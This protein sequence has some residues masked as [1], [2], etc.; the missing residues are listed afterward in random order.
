MAIDIA[1][2]TDLDAVAADAGGALDRTHQRCLFDRLDWYRLLLEHCPPAGEPLIVRARDGLGAVWLLL[3]RRSR[4]AT[5]LA[6][7]YSLETGPVTMGDTRSELLEALAHHLRVNHRLTMI[8]LAPMRE[9]RLSMMRAAFHRAGWITK[10]SG[11]STN[12]SICIAGPSWPDYLARR[13]GRLQ[14]TLRRKTRSNNLEIHI[15][16]QFNEDIWHSYEQIYAS[17]WKPQE[18]SPAFL[19]A[20]AKQESAAGTL[21]LGL[22]FDNGVPIAAQ[23]WLVENGEATIH[24]LAHAHDRRDQSPGTILTAAMFRHAIE[25]DKVQRIDFGTGNDPYKADWMDLSRP[26]FQLDLF[27]PRTIAGLTGALRGTLSTARTAI[28]RAGNRLRG[29]RNDRQTSD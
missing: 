7:W 1:S 23:F 29:L 27:N 11:I 8:S 10:C 15:I 19:T 3:T 17:S 2:F 25:Q 24:K 9:D 22:A 20:L 26:L 21:R 13:P 4:H 18:G 12:W 5:A 16:E 28:R 6:N 14:N